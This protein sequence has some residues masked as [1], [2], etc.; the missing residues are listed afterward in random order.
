MFNEIAQESLDDELNAFMPQHL[1]TKEAT[2]KSQLEVETAELAVCAEADLGDFATLK[3]KVT[4]AKKSAKDLIARLERAM[5][6]ARD[7]QAD[8]T[9]L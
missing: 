6:E 4:A 7:A 1:K 5:E 2:F 9:N 8:S 3:G